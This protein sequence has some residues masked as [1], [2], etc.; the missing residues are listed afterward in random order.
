MS[1][2][3]RHSESILIID[4][5]LENLQTLSY[6]LDEQGYQVRQAITAELALSTIRKTPPDIILLDILL[7]N[8]NGYELCDQ[9]K[10]DEHTREIPVLF[11]SVLGGTED[12]LKAF[13]VG[14]VDYLTKPFQEREVLARV[15]AL[16]KLRNTQKQLE[17]E[18]IERK[19]AEEQ[20]KASLKEKEVL[21]QEIHHRVKNNMQVVA[22][23][24]NLQKNRIDDE[25]SKA[26]FE[27]SKDRINSMGLVHELL[28]QSESL[29]DFDLGNYVK[30]LADNL[31]GVGG[32]NL[33]LAIEN[34]SVGIDQAV[35]CGLVINELISNSLKHAF[36]EGESGMLQIKGRLLGDEIELE[37]ADNGHGMPKDFDIGNTRTLGHM[38]V[39]GL[40][41]N[42]L[43]GTWDMSSSKAGTKHTMRFKRVD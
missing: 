24:L 8:M 35:P 15:K 1:T 16:L 9:L 2:F 20:V 41:E 6:I 10:A 37:I 13:D 21:L 42:Q 3:K 31:L 18:I 14:G 30:K 43:H 17:Q 28:Y 34:I 19:E 5:R 22:S 12:K 40:V 27:E 7:P 23:L 26:A 39:K 36:P 38:L 4:D 25:K 32:V 11:I 33:K 29:H